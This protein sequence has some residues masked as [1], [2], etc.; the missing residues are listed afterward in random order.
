MGLL[1]F[2]TYYGGKNRATRQGRYPA[3]DHHRLMEP[4]AGSA[5]YAMA[6]PDRD[7]WINDPDPAV[8]GTWAYLA[9]AEERE[10]LALPD[11]AEGQTVNDLDLPQGARWLIGW[12]LN[13]G[14]AQ[15]KLRPSSFMLHHAAGG[16]YW[17]GS[18]RRRIASQL[19]AIR[20]WT[21]TDHDYED[22]PN[23]EATWFIDPPYQTA[24][25]H[26]RFGSAGLDYARLGRWCESRRGQVIV[27]EEEG[28]DWLPFRPLYETD[29]TEGR[30]KPARRRVEAV[31]P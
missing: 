23:Y 24:G 25:R 11:L 7:V 9:N 16:P 30:Q 10:I 20:H 5:G 12:W 31:W 8:A 17:G 26:Y 14:G 1:P 13:K 22:L 27:C 18:I 29:Q 6:Y 28:A 21:I 19:G 15:P 4:F 2:F 3:P